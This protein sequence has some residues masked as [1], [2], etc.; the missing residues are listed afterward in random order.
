MNSSNL[1][2][3]SS[4]YYYQI[5]PLKTNS[6]IF[7][8]E[9][10]DVFKRGEVVCIF[11]RNKPTRGVVLNSCEKPDFVCKQAVTSGQ[12][13]GEHQIILADFIAQYYCCGYGESYGLFTPFE[14]NIHESF[15]MQESSDFYAE[16]ISSPNLPQENTPFFFDHSNPLTSPQ[17]KALDI[18]NTHT[19]TLLFGDTGSGKTEIYIQLIIEKLEKNQGIFFLMPEISLTPQ[20]EKR[21]KNVFGQTVG[22][23][24]SKITAKK[25]AQILEELKNG[26]IKIIAG[27]RSA[28]FLPMK[29]LG[30]IIVDEE[31]DDAYKS[32]NRPR[33]NARD[34]SLYLGN[35]TSIQVLLG[36]ATPSV[37]SYYN[38]L[39]NQSL[40]RLKGRHFESK[41]EIL[42]EVKSTQITPFILSHLQQTLEQNEQA[43]IFLPTRA[44]FKTLL[45]LECGHSVQCPFCSVDMSLHL[46]K[47]IMSCHYCDYTTSIPKICPR[48]QSP[49]L[50][51]ERV[52]TLQIANELKVLLPKARIAVFDRDHTSTQN[53]LNK[54]LDDFN[55]HRTDILIGTQ[56]ISKGHD[57]H[58]VNLAI[59][60]GIDYLLRS[61][62]Y[63]SYEKT[64]G[65]MYQVAGRSGRKSDGK[66]IIQS[67]NSDFLVNFLKNYEELLEFELKHHRVSYPPYA[68]I[69]LVLFSDK[70][71]EKAKANM[72]A[73][74]TILNGVLSKTNETVMDKFFTEIENRKIE[75]SM[76]MTSV[77]IVGAGKSKIE[78]IA[79]K[80]RYHIFLRSSSR[81]ALLRVLHIIAPYTKKLGFEI[82]IDPTHIG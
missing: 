50:S 21:L 67:L 6:P 32:Q 79:S 81:T 29:N 71:E 73:V 18:I 11:V 44:S 66:V 43:I 60:M 70:S 17:K 37:C 59:I 12:Y 30:L 26:K 19:Q 41:K 49:N 36:S 48:C 47:K 16:A 58:S 82:D 40:V 1:L 22:I 75:K 76:S 55:Q 68:R 7:T 27:A 25:K 31:H 69:A 77:D 39:Q 35:K 56:M 9:S 52:G 61:G 42:F 38:A 53:K 8:Y 74:L 78:K 45:C 34:L 54:I 65:L 15:L 13:F 20:I 64:I 3:S 63:Y 4:L 24:H 28:L 14:K 46:D 10:C 33:Y 5:A 51:G 62:D 57:Y 23:W 72:Q 80:Y 2:N